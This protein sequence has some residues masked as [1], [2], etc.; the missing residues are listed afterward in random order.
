MD[1][2]PSRPPAVLLTLALAAALAA[3]AAAGPPQT[4]PAP[5]VPALEARLA[6][7]P[8]DAEAAVQLGAAY[9]DARRL[10][11]AVRVLAA[12]RERDPQNENAVLLLGLVYEDRGEPARARELYRWYVDHGTSRRM[13]DELRGRLALLE[14]GARE[15]E[16][17][18]AVAQEARLANTPPTPNS[19][20]VF[21]FLF[22]GGDESLR[23]LERAL[24]EFLVTDL[25]QTGRLRVLERVRVQEML[26]EIALGESGRVDPATA[27]RGGRL[28]G[29]ANVVQGRFEGTEQALS[30][31]A[32][33]A[34]VTP[35]GA[36]P[37]GDAVGRRGDIQRL[38][39]MEKALAMGVYQRLDVQLSPAERER[40]MRIPTTNL[41][42]VLAF[43]RGLQ[44]ADA[45]DWAAAA[46]HFWEAARLDPNFS[47]ALNRAQE[48]ADAARAIATTTANL[49]EMVQ[50]KLAYG[51]EV[52][53]AVD[54][55]IPGAGVGAAVSQTLGLDGIRRRA[56]QVERLFRGPRER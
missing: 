56:A 25:S 40:V 5:D 34:R 33:V 29:A 24:A 6:A 37:A 17:R 27:A 35:T 31:E 28:L 10:D 45:G 9:R 3:C 50:I 41:Q 8:A 54:A 23:P 36:R 7:D 52:L 22:G 12:V 32:R 51:E 4:A 38:F 1:I 13:R 43:G 16:L 2:M 49:A 11:D 53:D 44:A 15:E 30:L 18:A 55:L 19:V 39:E 46:A 47:P 42:A 21:P 14:R 26:D 20:A 48:A